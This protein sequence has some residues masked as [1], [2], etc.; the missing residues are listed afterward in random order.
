M[1]AR[2][3]SVP[4]ARRM[5]THRRICPADLVRPSRLVLFLD[6][7][8]ARRDSVGNNATPGDTAP[9]RRAARTKFR[10]HEQGRA[11]D[12]MKRRKRNTRRDF[13]EAQRL[14]DAER[15]TLRY[16]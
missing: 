7:P 3:G 15:S 1:I 6:S 4:G 12:K 11:P 2:A 8:F 5:P 14:T 9:V 10:R 16:E 13:R